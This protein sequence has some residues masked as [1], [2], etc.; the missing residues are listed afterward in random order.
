MELKVSAD[1]WVACGERRYACALGRSG[2]KQDKREGDGA[3]P[4]GRFPLRRILYR[5]DRLSRPASD[6]PAEP[7]GPD[8]GW[9]DDPADA[10][11]YNRA[12]RLPH[13]SSCERLWRSDGLYDVV[14]VLGHN[15]DPPLPGAG[16]AI[17]LHVAKPGYGPTEGCVALALTDLLSVLMSCNTGTVI[18]IGVPPAR[19]SAAEVPAW[20][21]QERRDRGDPDV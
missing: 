11:H 2:L 6:L 12:V 21:L 5:M 3:T 14:V 13:P 1:G 15:D 17:F 7:I 9:C 10:A 20:L 18:D 4:I 16:S 8:D 19:T